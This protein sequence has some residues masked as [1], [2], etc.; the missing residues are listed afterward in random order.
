MSELKPTTSLER[1]DWLLQLDAEDLDTEEALI[2]RRLIA[3][4]ERLEADL[5]RMRDILVV[6]MKANDNWR[7]F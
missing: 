4:V 7:E 6:E 2:F 1:V 3:D 5:T